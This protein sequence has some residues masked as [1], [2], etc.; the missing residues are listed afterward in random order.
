MAKAKNP[1]N[2]NTSNTMRPFN[3]VFCLSLSVAFT[4]QSYAMTEME[5]RAAVAQSARQAFFDEDFAQLEKMSAAYRTEKSRTSSG[6]WKLSLFYSGLGQTFKKQAEREDFEPVFEVL[7][8]K[9]KKWAQQFPNSPSAH[10]VHSVVLIRHGWAYRGNGYA[11]SVRPE[12]WAPFERYIALAKDNL[13]KYKSVS[14][15]D[16]KWYELMLTVARTENWERSKFNSL[17]KEALDR[18]SLFY[19]TYFEALEYLLPKWHGELADVEAFAQD[20]VKRTRS[21]EGQGMYARIYWYASQTQFDTDIFRDSFAAWP[22]MRSGFED[23]IA[24]YPDAWNLNNY[25]KFACL[26]QDFSKTRELLKRTESTVVPEAWTP[27]FLREQCTKL[28]FQN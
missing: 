8:A 11:S 13:L 3:M 12:S 25:A 23:I 10:I 9:T 27:P 18:E 22:K 2:P 16:P 19:Q 21:E 15:S 24:R 14:S 28:A 26:A 17:L 1:I 4:A 7:E 5:E 20:A 6:L